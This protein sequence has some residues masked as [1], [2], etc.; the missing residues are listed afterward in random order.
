MHIALLLCKMLQAHI[1]S[2]VSPCV[3]IHLCSDQSKCRL[4]PIVLLAVTSPYAFEAM[5][6]NALASNIAVTS[7]NA[8]LDPIV[9]LA[10]GP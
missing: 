3:W 5:Q 7:P 10:V 9:L 2:T 6:C 8:D 1:N 4:D